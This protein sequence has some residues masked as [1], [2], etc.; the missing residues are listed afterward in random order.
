MSDKDDKMPDAAGL[1]APAD[2]KGRFQSELFWRGAFAMQ[3]K[4]NVELEKLRARVAIVEAQRDGL[5]AAISRDAKLAASPATDRP[6]Q[7]QPAE[8]PGKCDTPR[9][10]C[11]GICMYCDKP[12][13]P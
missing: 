8:G 1:E 3:E 12:R 11:D 5:P 10:D 4:M 2:I 7:Q 6:A 9:F 13:L